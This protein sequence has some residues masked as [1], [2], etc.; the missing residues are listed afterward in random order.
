MSEG[1]VPSLILSLTFVLLPYV[2]YLTTTFQAYMSHSQVERMVVGK[3]FFFL[4]FNVF[5][6]TTFSAGLVAGLTTLIEN[7]SG[8]PT[9]L[10]RNIPAQ[11]NFFLC[12]NTPQSCPHGPR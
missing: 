5:L 8:L 4:L 3:F 9:E 1:T 6:L 2:L 7:P 12:A 10:G 11:S